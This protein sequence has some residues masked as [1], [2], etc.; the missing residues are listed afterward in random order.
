MDSSVRVQGLDGLLD[1]MRRLPPEIV[2]KNGGP[3][4]TALARGAR[5][6]RDEVRAN[7]PERTGFL[8]SQIVTLRS[9]RP[10]AYGGSE[11]YSIGVKGGARARYA[12]TRRNRGKGRVGKT[13]EKPSNAFYWR[14]QEFG[15]P[16]RNIPPLAFFRRSLRKLAEPVIDQFADDL[17]RSLDRITRKLRRP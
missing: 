15:V 2:S 14:F 9:P 16:S 17:R 4:R 8:K 12:N 1:A 5:R 10:Q 7:A 13:Y 6:M 3:A 11:L